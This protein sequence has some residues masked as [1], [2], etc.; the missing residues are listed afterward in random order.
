MTSLD[1][2]AVQDGVPVQKSAGTPSPFEAAG[3]PAHEALE[4]AE[5]LKVVAGFA[6]GPLGAERVRQRRPSTNPG[7]IRGE[8]GPVAELLALREKNEA[9]DV[10][11][12]PP[13]EAILD[14]LR[15]EGS[16]LEGLELVGIRTTLSAARL[17]MSS[18]V[19]AT[20]ATA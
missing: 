6:A 4:F 19:A 3:F 11:P 14:R 8:L 16:V 10:P 7:W 12:V 9:I 15:L 2:T 13:L 20:A 5:V 17:A 1:L 18:V